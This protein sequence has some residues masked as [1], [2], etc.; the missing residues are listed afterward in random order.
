MLTVIC[1]NIPFGFGRSRLATGP[2][3]LKLESVGDELRLL[4]DELY[5]DVALGESL[6]NALLPRIDKS[7]S[8][9]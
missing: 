5:P 2:M 4:E 9:N 3:K 7:S 8:K 6:G 1:D